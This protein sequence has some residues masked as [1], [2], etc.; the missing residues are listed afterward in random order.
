MRETTA[1]IEEL[2]RLL[3]V[4]I[5]RASGFLRTSFQ[6]PERSLSAGQLADRLQGLRTVALATSTSRGEPRV[7]PIGAYFLRGHFHVPTVAE[8]S[9]ARHLLRR[10]DASLTYFEG[11]EFALIAHGSVEMIDETEPRFEEL[12]AVQVEIGGSSVRAWGGTAVFLRLRC[13]ALFTYSADLGTAR[14]T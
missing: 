1:D 9:R 6:M 5:D 13:R 3:D 8:S 7:A 4:S 2:Q 12:D 11:T 14:D 10:P